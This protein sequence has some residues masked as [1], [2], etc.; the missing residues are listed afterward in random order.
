MENFK[1][2]WDTPMNRKT[3]WIRIGIQL[4]AIMVAGGLFF[5][6]ADSNSETL[7]G[8]L[9]GVLAIMVIYIIPYSWSTILNRAWDAGYG[10]TG[11][12]MWVVSSMIIGRVDPTGILSILLIIALGTRASDTAHENSPFPENYSAAQ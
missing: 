2:N 7:S 12:V 3:F 11:R 5:L 8:I 1:I 10:N 4:V 9:Y 6:A